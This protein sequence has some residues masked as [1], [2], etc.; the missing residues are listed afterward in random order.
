[1]KKG[2]LDQLD[3]ARCLKKLR[4]ENGLTQQ[5]L[6][7]KLYCDVRQVR[8]YE[9]KG[10]ERISVINEY[11]DIFNISTLSILSASAS[12]DAF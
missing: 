10:T 8:R 2:Q 4:V 12:T 9:T 5:A 11:A 7:D 1:M 6:A 3:I